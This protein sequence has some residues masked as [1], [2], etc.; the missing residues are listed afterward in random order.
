MRA[1]IMM[2]IFTPI[3]INVPQEQDIEVVHAQ[4]DTSGRTKPHV[5]IDL[6]LHFS[7]GSLY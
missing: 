4:G 6:K 2:V 3:L 5:D 7:I 1:R